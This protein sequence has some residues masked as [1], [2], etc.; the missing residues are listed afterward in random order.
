MKHGRQFVGVCLRVGADASLI[1]CSCAAATEPARDND[2]IPI[3]ENRP[4]G[5]LDSRIGG[6]HAIPHETGTELDAPRPRGAFAYAAVEL[7]DEW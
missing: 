3:F 6:Q 1:E 2:R 5:L 7:A 4:I